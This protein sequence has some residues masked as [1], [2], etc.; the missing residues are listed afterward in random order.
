MA[1]SR[2]NNLDQLGKLAA[3]LRKAFGEPDGV[4]DL[5]VGSPLEAVGGSGSARAAAVT[6]VAVAVAPV[7]VGPAS[8][9]VVP[10]GPAALNGSA[11]GSAEA[12]A[13]V[14]VP[15]PASAADAD[16]DP[17]CHLIYATLLD[18]ASESKARSAYKRLA[19]AFVDWNELRVTPPEEIADILGPVT[20]AGEKALA[21]TKFL[22]QIFEKRNVLS[23]EFLKDKPK[24]EARAY[25]ETLPG[26]TPSAAAWV[27]LHCLDG[28][29]V[30]AD[31]GVQRLLTRLGLIE[32]ETAPAQLHGLLERAVSAKEAA[33]VSLLLRRQAEEVCVAA[34]PKCGS[35]VLQP[36]CPTGRKPAAKASASTAASGKHPARS[37]APA[38]AV[39]K[40]VS[41]RK[42]K[43]RN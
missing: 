1:G 9:A 3:A 6:A 22:H 36:K 29:A 40:K 37:S 34:E 25:L 12:V 24:R 17:V 2:S 14:V 5:P 42:N 35:C 39:V 7:P 38:K 10:G 31:P 16:R 30:P 11:H 19:E 15:P 32:A 43:S 41:L 26:V 4:P 23:L 18:G 28:H 8:P 21:L 20:G 27:M 33:S 13:T